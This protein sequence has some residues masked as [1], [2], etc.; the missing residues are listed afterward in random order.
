MRKIKIAAIAALAVVPTL[1]LA[2]QSSDALSS[3]LHPPSPVSSSRP[4]ES[5]PIYLKT[6]SLICQKWQQLR[7]TAEEAARAPDSEQERIV[8]NRNCAV[9]PADTRVAIIKTDPKSWDGAAEKTYG[10]AKVSWHSQF[11]DDSGYVGVGA[12]RN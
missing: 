5:L 9:V 12:L 2:D 7:G 6:G 8:R 11:G 10:F 4:N 1:A 3:A